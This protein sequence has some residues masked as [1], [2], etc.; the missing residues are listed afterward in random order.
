MVTYY[1]ILVEKVMKM[2]GMGDYKLMR[3]HMQLWKKNTVIESF[4]RVS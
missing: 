2:L 3:L 1:I 4:I